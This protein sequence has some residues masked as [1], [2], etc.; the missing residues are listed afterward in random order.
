MQRKKKKKN[1]IT[2]TVYEE[3]QRFYYDYG[4]KML[5]DDIK[6]RVILLWAIAQY[7]HSFVRF[8]DRV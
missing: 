3:Y 5:I 8:V 1:A 7:V 2:D 4:N 6:S